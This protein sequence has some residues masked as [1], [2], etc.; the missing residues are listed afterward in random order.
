MITDLTLLFLSL[1]FF[2]R[3]A[4]RGFLKSI[5]GPLAL[6]IATAAAFLVYKNTNNVVLSLIIGVAGPFVLNFILLFILNSFRTVASSDFGPNIFSRL[7]GA[8]VTFAWGMVFIL[9]VVL[10]LAVVPAFHPSIAMIQKDIKQSACFILIR[11]LTHYVPSFLSSPGKSPTITTANRQSLQAIASTP[12]MKEL[13][14]DP[15]IRQAIEQK[16]YA[17]L[18]TNPKIMALTQDPGFIKKILAAYEHMSTG[19]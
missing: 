11:P 8:A 13:L 19:Q 15:E 17:K 14:D 7:M 3:G 16:N 5:L 12:Q 6:A 4:S 9:P 1:F 10:F 18:M 2:W